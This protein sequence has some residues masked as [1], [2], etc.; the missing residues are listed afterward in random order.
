MPL[1]QL[2]GKLDRDGVRELGRWGGRAPARR[3]SSPQKSASPPA[4]GAALRVRRPAAPRSSPQKSPPFLR[5]R[6][7]RPAAERLLF[8]D[9]APRASGRFCPAVVRRMSCQRTWNAIVCWLVDRA[10]LDRGGRGRNA[11]PGS[12]DLPDDRRAVPAAPSRRAPRRARGRGPRR[13]AWRRRRSCS[14]AR[15][16]RR[17]SR[18]S[19]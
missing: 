15:R 13:A 7:R 19:R 6:R 2:P 8:R 4:G 12:H 17:A 3:R 10:D 9:A 1:G 16:R 11:R 18:C 14:R 5:G